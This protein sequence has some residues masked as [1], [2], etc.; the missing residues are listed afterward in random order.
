[1]T[2]KYGKSAPRRRSPLTGYMKS[3]LQRSLDDHTWRS[4]ALLS[5]L[6]GFSIEDAPPDRNEWTPGHRLW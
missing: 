1:M 5:W 4:H 2:A 3:S 6:R